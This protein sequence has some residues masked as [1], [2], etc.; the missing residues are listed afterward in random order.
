[1]T[2]LRFTFPL[3]LFRRIGIDTVAAGSN[4]EGITT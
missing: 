1:V 4:E 3:Q 2:E